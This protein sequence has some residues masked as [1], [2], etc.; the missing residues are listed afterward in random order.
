MLSNRFL[1]LDPDPYEPLD[2]RLDI[3][4]LV[5]E[6][7]R[8][9]SHPIK[10]QLRVVSLARSEGRYYEA[11]SYCWDDDEK[12]NLINVN[13]R[14]YY[15]TDSLNSFLR[16][17][18]DKDQSVTLWIDAIC[19]NQDD[20][21]EKQKQV[22]LMREIYLCSNRLT[23]WLGSPSEDTRLAFAAMLYILQGDDLKLPYLDG[24][25]RRALNSLFDRPLWTRIWII[26]EI[27]L[28]TMFSNG[29][30]AI[31]QCGDFIAPMPAFWEVIHRIS[32]YQIENRQHFP[33][34]ERIVG[35]W[36]LR[37]SIEGPSGEQNL[38][39]LLSGRSFDS[40]PTLLELMAEY[41]QHKASDARDKVYGL[42]GISQTEDDFCRSIIVNYEAPASNLYSRV[43]SFVIKQ[44]GNLDLLKHCRG[45]VLKGLPSWV[46][47][48][49]Y[50][51]RGNLLSAVLAQDRENNIPQ[52]EG[53]DAESPEDP[54]E[55]ADQACITGGVAAISVNADLT[56]GIY[57]HRG[58]LIARI[59][60]E[61]F[62]SVRDDAS[63]S[64]CSL[65]IKDNVLWTQAI[66]LDELKIVHAPF[67]DELQV[68]WEACTEFMVA[69]GR[70]KYSVLHRNEEE[71]NPYQ[72]SSRKE[73]SFW[74]AIFGCDLYGEDTD[75][76][77]IIEN[78]NQ[79]WL[80]PVPE[81]GRLRTLESPYCL[82]VS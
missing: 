60:N 43:A 5:L 26:Q 74:A 70:C 17:R 19:I 24:D 72:T 15:I 49:S 52:V 14:P 68:R 62:H 69:V 44:H 1:A 12:S 67:P 35:L 29:S 36:V 51:R 31:L 18:R 61:Y 27:I 37:K 21:E 10:C 33:S 55:R 6:P 77:S 46:P 50:F 76:R 34:V 59:W 81:N 11:V 57:K 78:K 4:T 65:S 66:V 73:I 2:C 42:L 40:A 79:K 80:P 54:E 48:W 45:Q 20:H 25:S 7:A 82:P 75:L 23:V 41:R 30:A 39:Q 16:Y 28:G 58:S 56:P 32:N 13:E 9:W 63:P 64:S 22:Q 71:P 8:L 3:R 53:S 38:D 47:D